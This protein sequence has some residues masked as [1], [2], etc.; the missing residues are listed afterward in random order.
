[1]TGGVNLGYDINR[2]TKY[3]AR[4]EGNMVLGAYEMSFNKRSQLIY[5]ASKTSTNSYFIRKRNW[6]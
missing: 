1:M 2:V 3:A 6:N 4:L 5:R